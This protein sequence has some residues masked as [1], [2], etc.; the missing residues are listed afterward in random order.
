M[1][2]TSCIAVALQL[3]TTAVLSYLTKIAMVMVQWNKVRSRYN[4]SQRDFSEDRPAYLYIKRANELRS[5]G[6][7]A[8]LVLARF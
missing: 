5:V 7:S 1:G 8:T 6:C 4:V 3:R 2:G